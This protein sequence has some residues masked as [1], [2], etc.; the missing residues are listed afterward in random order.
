M[1][2][3][4]MSSSVAGQRWAEPEARVAIRVAYLIRSLEAGGAE[5]QLVAL[6]RGLDRQAFAP[7]VLTYYPGGAL[8]AELAAAGLAPICLNKGGRWDNLGFLRRLRRTLG[9]LDP[10]I[11]HS[12]MTTAN[13]FALAARSAAPRARLVW[14][15]RASAVRHG[16]Y[17]L[18][19]GL[20]S[21]LAER[22]ERA[23]CRRPAVIL[24]NSEAGREHLLGQ[25]VPAGK[26][27]VVE[28]GIDCERFRPMPEA[29]TRLRAEWGLAPDAPV[30]GLAARL[31]PMKG[32]AVFLEAAA[33]ALRQRP[34]LRFVC[35]GGGSEGRSR[36]LRRR[37]D[38][39]G[40]GERIIWAGAR[41]DMPE[42][43]NA[44][45]VNV[46]ASLFGEGFSNAIGE[47]MAAGVPCVVTGVGDSARIVGDEGVVVA[48]GDPAALAAGWARILALEP[49]ARQ[50]LGARCRARIVEHFSL[51][52]M[53]AR[54]AG[55]YRDV[56]RA[57]AAPAPDSREG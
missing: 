36:P 56:L 31:D 23:F 50:A 11:I 3:T 30:I 15:L 43:L 38:A 57:D 20:P 41:G 26:I 35:L 47:A 34:A 27:A 37:A 19:Q 44:V 45:D 48:P 1:A 2:P 42:A 49:A 6:V 22:V 54:T 32:H 17:G 39:L 33:L 7:T 14:S 40:L 9:R 16:R 21:A 4:S 46:S 10:A 25:G 24:A 8:E 28:N 18:R 52:R 51:E 12:Y 29:R 13:L 5:R 53:V 55:L